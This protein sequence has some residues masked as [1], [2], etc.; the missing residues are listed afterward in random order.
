MNGRKLIAGSVFHHPKVDNVSPVN[1]TPLSFNQEKGTASTVPV[2]EET[3]TSTRR[4]SYT[5]EDVVKQLEE[6]PQL[7]KLQDMT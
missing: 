6:E 7:G 2:I 3:P 4:V 1:D 5:L